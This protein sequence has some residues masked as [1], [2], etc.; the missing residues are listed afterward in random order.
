MI[1]VVPLSTPTPSMSG[2]LGRLLIPAIL[3]LAPSL[4]VAQEE[5][6]NIVD[7]RL[8]ALV[9]PNGTNTAPVDVTEQVKANDIVNWLVFVV[10]GAMVLGVMF[11]NPKRSHLD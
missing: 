6:I 9:D 4:A 8:E 10:L 1:A 3:L 11:I 5:R 2:R 7:A